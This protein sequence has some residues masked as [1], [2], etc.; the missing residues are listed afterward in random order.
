MFG[1]HAGQA[2]ETLKESIKS[3]PWR[4][5]KADFYVFRQWRTLRGWN[6]TSAFSKVSSD[7]WDSAKAELRETKE[8]TLGDEMMVLKQQG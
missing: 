8:R 1:M 5:Y 2:G 3:K 6:Y 7:T 4:P